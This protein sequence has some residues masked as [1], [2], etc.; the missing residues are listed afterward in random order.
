MYYL[1]NLFPASIRLV[2]GR[3]ATEGQLEVFLDGEWG[4][5]CGNSWGLQEATVACR[6]MG[7]PNATAVNHGMRFRN[8]TGTIHQYDVNCTGI[9]NGLL[10]CQRI[11]TVEGE[12]TGTHGEGV[13]L[14][15]APRGNQEFNDESLNYNSLDQ[16]AGRWF[17]NPVGMAR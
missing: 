15:C 11:E 9:E 16:G 4:T 10:S 14:L 5:V 6:E 13:V 7:F 1:T 3:S 2:G 8:V 17:T 12:C